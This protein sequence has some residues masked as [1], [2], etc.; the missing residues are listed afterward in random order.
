LDH[1]LI[2]PVVWL[3]RPSVRGREVSA[4]WMT[5]AVTASAQGPLATP[6]Q[7]VGRASCLWY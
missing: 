2:G 4:R 7:L 3:S 1:P 5:T 6:S